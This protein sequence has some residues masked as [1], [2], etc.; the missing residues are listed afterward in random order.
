MQIYPASAVWSL[1]SVGTCLLKPRVL[2]ASSG[3]QSLQRV[4][5]QQL[6][7]EVFAAL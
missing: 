3:V 6:L 1:I 5:G 7:Q 2:L 4:H